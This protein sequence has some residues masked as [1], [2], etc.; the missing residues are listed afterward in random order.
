MV[1]VADGVCENPAFQQTPSPPSSKT[2]SFFS[3]PT[4]PSLLQVSRKGA[5]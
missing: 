2:P 1:V 4:I 3:P 5:V